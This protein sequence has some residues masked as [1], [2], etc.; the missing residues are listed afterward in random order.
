MGLLEILNELRIWTPYLAGGFMMNLL[1]SLLSMGLGT[2]VGWGLGWM[3][4]LPY[5]SLNQSGALLTSLFRNIPSFVFMFYIAFILPVEINW[6]DEVVKVPAWIK[7]SIAL[8]VPVTGF[9]SDQV[10]KLYQDRR[11]GGHHPLMSFGL[12]WTQYF[13]IIIMASSTASVIGVDEI[14]ARA[15]T[16]IAAIRAP[17][18]MLWLYLYVAL[19]FLLLGRVVSH[20]ANRLMFSSQMSDRVVRRG[21]SA[22]EVP[23]HADRSP[24]ETEALIRLGKQIQITELK[25]SLFSGN[26]RSLQQQLLP[27]LLQHNGGYTILDCHALSDLDQA[28]IRLLRRLHHLALDNRCRLVLTGLQESPTLSEKLQKSGI[29]YLVGAEHQFETVHDAIFACEDRLLDRELG[30]HR[31]HTTVP[32]SAFNI[33]KLFS[34]VELDLFETY[35]EQQ[36]YPAKTV[37]SH[38]GDQDGRLLLVRS[39]RVLA[40]SRG[41]HGR[42][43][44]LYAFCPGSMI[45]EMALLDNE[46]RSA[47]IVAEMD[48]AVAELTPK[49]FK[50][51]QQEQPQLANRLLSGIGIVM[52]QKIRTLN[53]T[54]MALED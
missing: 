30:P 11:A 6:G 24:A 39:G 31:Y 45:G 52:S 42:S 18:I 28:A 22:L 32:W 54:V 17:E 19:W 26:C 37:I 2:A 33:L 9:V 15:N 38:Q 48:L 29:L 1:L 16:V 49:A 25:G 41:R 23:G 47:T 8:M 53:R 50:R 36:R 27:L 40:L 21:Y 14:V 13:I 10:V 12:A 34:R 51:L 44:L 35:L 5:R 7:A 4:T 46:P 3:R 20:I 43:K